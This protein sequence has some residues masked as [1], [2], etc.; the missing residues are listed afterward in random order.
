MEASAK[1]HV[2]VVH[3]LIEAHADVNTRS[4][5]GKGAI[6]A[7]RDGGHQEVVQLLLQSGAWVCTYRYDDNKTETSYFK[8][9]S[10]QSQ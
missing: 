3:V 1:G 8:F 10:L 7:A 2:A 9:I 4:P 5:F 6:D